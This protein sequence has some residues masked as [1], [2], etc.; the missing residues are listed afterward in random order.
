MLMQRQAET[1]RNIQTV[2]TYL[3]GFRKNDHER[4]LLLDRRHLRS[5]RSD[6]SSRTDCNPRLRCSA[7]RASTHSSTRPAFSN[8]GES[9]VV[10]RQKRRL[11][12]YARARRQ[13]QPVWGFAMRAAGV[14][15]RAL[16]V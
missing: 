4:N 9:A 12:P 2:N 15:W 8:V 3:D 14:G 7:S 16:V 1:S 11:R 5:T 10:A 6:I 13:R